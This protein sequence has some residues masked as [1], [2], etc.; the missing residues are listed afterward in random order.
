M[1][2]LNVSSDAVFINHITWLNYQFLK[3]RAHLN[4]L[5]NVF[6]MVFT[7]LLFL[8]FYQKL[9]AFYTSFFTLFT[10]KKKC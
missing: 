10:N 1:M 2:M 4:Y 5:I 8:S 6:K 7:N 3:F 9:C